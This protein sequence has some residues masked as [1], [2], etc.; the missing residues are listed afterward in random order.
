MPVFCVRG[1]DRY[2]NTKREVYVEAASSIDATE[3]G[4]RRGIVNV[5]VSEVDRSEIPETASVIAFNPKERPSSSG[6]VLFDHP[7][8]SIALGI[9]FGL[10]G[11]VILINLLHVVLSVIGGTLRLFA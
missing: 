1:D 10:F 6:V 4:H 2:L 7:A 11:F 9:M 5:Q 8:R 3:F